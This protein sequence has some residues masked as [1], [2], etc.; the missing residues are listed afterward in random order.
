MGGGSYGKP[1]LAQI[2]HCVATYPTA[3]PVH[4]GYSA[5]SPLHFPIPTAVDGARHIPHTSSDLSGAR[6]TLLP[7]PHRQSRPCCIAQ[8]PTPP[9][10]DAT[11]PSEHHPLSSHAQAPSATLQHLATN[12][13]IPGSAEFL[14]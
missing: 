6:A 7:V 12:L 1:S 5:H 11:S 2:P 10:S 4:L 9:T 3:S 13:A 8:K 14:H